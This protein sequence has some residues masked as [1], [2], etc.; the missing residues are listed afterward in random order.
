MEERC[1]KPD[2]DMNG[3]NRVEEF[4]SSRL[5]RRSFPLLS[6][7]YPLLSFPCGRCIL[8]YFDL[9]SVVETHEREAP[10]Q[11]HH[12]VKRYSPEE[13]YVPLI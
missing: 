2:R 11:P 9:H 4:G 3:K 5:I 1:R 6:V 10:Y 13:L 8:C 7:I 12:V